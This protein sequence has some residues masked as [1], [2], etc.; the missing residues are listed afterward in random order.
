MLLVL[1]GWTYH[2]VS[3]T[4]FGHIWRF[5]YGLRLSVYFSSSYWS[6]EQ[7]LKDVALIAPPGDHRRLCASSTEK[8]PHE[9]LRGRLELRRLG[10]R[11][12]RDHRDEIRSV[13]ARDLSSSGVVEVPRAVRGL[14]ERVHEARETSPG[15]RRSCSTR[16]LALVA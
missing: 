4:N 6:I 9:A 14:F 7:V 8:P 13:D 11:V 16:R 5:C 2:W 10:V 12:G 3:S 1:R 15:P